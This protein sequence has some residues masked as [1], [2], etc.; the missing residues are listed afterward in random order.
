MKSVLIFALIVTAR[1]LLA[2]APG[3][4]VRSISS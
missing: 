3:R 1:P 4:T 2:Q